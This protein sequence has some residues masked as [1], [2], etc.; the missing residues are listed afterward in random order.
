MKEIR[1]LLFLIILLFAC[2]ASKKLS[3]QNDY[4][5]DSIIQ[6][7]KYTFKIVNNE[8]IGNGKD[9]LKKEAGNSQFFMIGELHGNQETPLFTSA[10]LNLLKPVGYNNFAIEIGPF[11]NKKLL[12]IIKQ[13][14][15]VDSLSNFYKKYN[16]DNLTNP[17]PF[18]DGM[19][20]V[21][22]LQT[23][24]INNYTI[25]GIDQEF[26]YAAPFLFDEIFNTVKKLKNNSKD[27]EQI[28]K[29]AH[30]SLLKH[31]T[32]KSKSKFN[33]LLMDKHILEFISESK[34]TDNEVT[35]LLT[36][37]EKSWQIYAYGNG[38]TKQYF[39][40][41]NSRAIMMKH[42]F[43]DY[44][45]KALLKEPNPKMVLKMGSMHTV[46]GKNPLAI[47]DI[48][49]TL[50]ELAILNSSKSFNLALAGRYY[51]RSSGEK[52]DRLK[53]VPEY[54]KL[55]EHQEKNLWTLLDLRPLKKA[56]YNGKI[57][58]DDKKFKKLLN[59]YDSVLLKTLTAATEDI[60]DYK[61]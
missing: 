2:F 41:N 48:G 9:F 22:M 35:T 32:T 14:N 37:L 16:P 21:R 44:Y 29:K 53:Y 57:K 58:I 55:F 18:F 3:A 28:Y 19:D 5:I 52:I 13:K 42:Y 6:S 38:P 60:R 43:F 25:W 50:Y 1:K 11:S 54:K 56:I 27:Y 26:V 39:E 61:K 59:R 49:N 12:S 20:E 51:I 17:I 40:S 34:G 33:L 36:E 4:S 10:I 15:G 31:L 8:I 46:Y 30:A 23:A 47:Y 45:K 7:N 24:L